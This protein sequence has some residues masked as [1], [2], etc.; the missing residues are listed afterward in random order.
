MGLP[1]EH[2]YAGEAGGHHPS[3]PRASSGAPVS[4]HRYLRPTHP[5]EIGHAAPLCQGQSNQKGELS[6]VVQVHRH[7]SPKGVKTNHLAGFLNLAERREMQCLAGYPRLAEGRETSRRTGFPNLVKATE[8]CR[9]TIRS[10]EIEA[11]PPTPKTHPSL[12][13]SCS[14]LFATGRM[15]KRH[16]QCMHRESDEPLVCDTCKKGYRNEAC[17][18]EHQAQYNPKRQHARSGRTYGV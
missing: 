15:A 7:F 4:F 3:I 6:A 8:A 14:R 18:K 2:V 1:T 13:A 16:Y 9:V 12:E 17:L 11:P 5:L 10:G